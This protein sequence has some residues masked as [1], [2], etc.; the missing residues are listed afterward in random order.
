M[1]F[2]SKTP[3]HFPEQDFFG[4]FL[5]KKIICCFSVA[6]IFLYEKTAGTFWKI[7]GKIS[8]SVIESFK[9][10]CRKNVVIELIQ[11]R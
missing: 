6:Q 7:S 2:I 3:G 11:L 5:F 10:I 8:N 4:A 1:N 9:D